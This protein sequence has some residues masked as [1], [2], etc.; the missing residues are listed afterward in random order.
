MLPTFIYKDQTEEN[1]NFKFHID[2]KN[3][4]KNDINKYDDDDD[5]DRLI[6]PL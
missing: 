3:K 6:I 2:K 4:V 1:K 5:D